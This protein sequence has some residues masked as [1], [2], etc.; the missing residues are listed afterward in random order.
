MG[1]EGFLLAL[2]EVTTEAS[3]VEYAVA[4]LVTLAR[5][6]DDEALAKI[7]TRVGGARSELEALRKGGR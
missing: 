7:L 5:G 6:Q 3:A 4:Y 2:G 1:D